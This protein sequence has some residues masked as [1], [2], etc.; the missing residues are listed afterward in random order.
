MRLGWSA[1]TEAEWLK[2]MWPSAAHV[3]DQL[4]EERKA[5]EPEMERK[6]NAVAVAH[7]GREDELEYQKML[8][9]ENRCKELGV[10]TFE[11]NR[12]PDMRVIS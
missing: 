12:P 3:I 1:M 4:L 2:D 5:V 10:Q 8:W 7:A 11:P 6:L 9:I